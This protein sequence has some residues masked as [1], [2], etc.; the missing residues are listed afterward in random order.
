[1][2]IG[3]L[4]ARQKAEQKRQ[5]GSFAYFKTFVKCDKCKTFMWSNKKKLECRSCGYEREI[6]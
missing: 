1:M 5:R 3:N 6:K 4:K 2:S